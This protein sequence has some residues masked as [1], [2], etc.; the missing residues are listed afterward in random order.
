MIGPMIGPTNCT[1]C[2]T[3]P[4]SI[5]IHTNEKLAFKC[6]S[7]LSDKMSQQSFPHNQQIGVFNCCNNDIILYRTNT[8]EVSKYAEEPISL[9]SHFSLGPLPILGSLVGFTIFSMV[10]IMVQ[11]LRKV[12]LFH[13]RISHQSCCVPNNLREE[14]DKIKITENQRFEVCIY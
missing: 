4:L 6:T 14:I 7:K 1:N 3:L 8:T 2:S 5:L 13:M 9:I 12:Q 10:V 11:F